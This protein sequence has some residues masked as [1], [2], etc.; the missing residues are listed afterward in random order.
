MIIFYTVLLRRRHFLLTTSSLLLVSCGQGLGLGAR[1][2][3]IIGGGQ[4]IPPN[5]RH[6]QY[7]LS[8]LEL[9]Q[10]QQHLSPM[11]FLPHGIHRNPQKASQLA[12]F[13]KIGPGA[14]EYDLD[15]RKVIR[16]IAALPDHL[17]YGHGAYST[18]G[19]LL[20]A[21]E[22]GI[23]TKDGTI[24]VRD[25]NTLSVLGRFPSYGKSPHE[26]K[27]VDQGRTMLVTN[28]GGVQGD[29]PPSVSY[30][31][32]D[33]QKLLERVTLENEDLNAGHVALSSSGQLLVVSAPRAGLSQR[34]AGGVSMGVED[35]KLL[36]AKANS[37]VSEKL[38]GEALSV[39]IHDELNLAAVTHPDGNILTIWSL[40]EQR[41][42]KSIQ[43]PGP[44]G[45]E[46]SSDQSAFIVSFGSEASVLKIPVDTLEPERKSTQ[47]GTFITG[48]H[49]YN[50]SSGI[51][52]LNYSSG[53]R[54]S[55]SA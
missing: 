38:F 51:R 31:D 30:I 45:V 11:T 15:S 50:W 34:R 44:R 52:E 40:K 39:S 47:S 5:G 23:G 7:V 13:E 32:V 49:I 22:S 19:S 53:V 18:D 55:V 4:F 35:G 43:L 29:E 2:N 6:K 26:C 41:L 1:T 37:V 8:V 48:S 14:C 36:Q 42:L 10:Q 33:S 9:E 28:G 17:F 24:S 54:N 46:L 20:F 21:T 25:A 3:L 27:L 16:P 12:V